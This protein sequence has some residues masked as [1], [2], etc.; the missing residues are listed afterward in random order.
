ML[1]KNERNGSVTGGM[2]KLAGFSKKDRKVSSFRTCLP[3]TQMADCQGLAVLT[4]V[5]CWELEP[6][7]CLPCH[8]GTVMTQFHDLVDSKSSLEIMNTSFYS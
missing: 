4:H 6:P 3:N 7:Q 8:S 5:K 2:L 1:L